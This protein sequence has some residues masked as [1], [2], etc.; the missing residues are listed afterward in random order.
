MGEKKIPFLCQISE[1]I[2]TWGKFA[3]QPDANKKE[4]IH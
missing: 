4:N 3:S 1:V 2:R